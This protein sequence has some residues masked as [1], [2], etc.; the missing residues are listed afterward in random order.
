MYVCVCGMLRCAVRLHDDYLR[1]RH[2]R[3][4]SSCIHYSL[5]P[6]DILVFI[7]IAVSN[8]TGSSFSTQCPARKENPASAKIRRCRTGS[9]RCLA[10]IATGPSKC[11][12][13]LLLITK[14]KSC[15]MDLAE[16]SASAESSFG[17]QQQQAVLSGGCTSPSNGTNSN[18]NT[19]CLFYSPTAI[20]NNS[21]VIQSSRASNSW[22]ASLRSKPNNSQF[23]QSSRYITT[24]N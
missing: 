16:E 19:L 17:Q 3:L 2:K 4:L 18:G 6:G 20:R 10:C 24:T 21:C 7:F 5:L 12:P 23:H 15:T 8:P 1:N 9:T 14:K 11:V 22:I 13:G